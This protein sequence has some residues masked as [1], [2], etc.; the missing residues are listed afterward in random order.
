MLTDSERSRHKLIYHIVE[1]ADSPTRRRDRGGK[2]RGYRLSI[3]RKTIRVLRG[4]KAF[5][6][7]VC[8]SPGSA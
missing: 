4:E 6:P 7:G 2:G 3:C 5:F 1:L 8:V